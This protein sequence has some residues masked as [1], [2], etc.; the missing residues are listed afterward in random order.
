MI[1]LAGFGILAMVPPLT[2]LPTLSWLGMIALLPAAYAIWWTWRLPMDFYRT[3]AVQPA[4]LFTFVLYAA[5]TGLGVV[6][7]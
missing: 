5:G 3:R 7:G 1:Y 2:G 6:M 4:A